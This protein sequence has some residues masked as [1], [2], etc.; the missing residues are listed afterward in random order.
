MKVLILSCSTG[1]GHNS[2]AKYIKQELEDNNISVDFYDF[3]DIVNEKAK[4]L[5]SK[6]YLMTLGNNGKLFKNIYKLGELYSKTKIKSPVYLVNK[7]YT[8]KLYDFIDKNKYDLI[9]T[10]HLFPALTLTAIN[11]N[12]NFTHI[13]FLFV[14]TDYEPCPFIEEAKPNYF[15]MQKGIE[16]KFYKKGIRKEKLLN[17]G[18]PIST[19]FIDNAKNIKK[20][21]NIL[22]E[23]VILIMLGSMGF[24]NINEI[25]NDLLKKDN[26]KIIIVCGSNENLF[27]SLNKIKNNKLIVLGFVNNINDLIYSSDIILSKPGGLSSTEIAVF[28]KPLIHIFP[29]PGIE[30]YNSE[31]FYNKKMS[32]KADKNEDIIKNINILLDN[33]NLQKDIINNQKKYINCYSGKDLIDFIKNNYKEK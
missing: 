1:G 27:N 21:F 26:I 6:M 18:I 16:N 11:K 15:I 14:A 7:L 29:I 19:K 23:K 31:F 24:G 9:I 2:C 28:R 32:L 17:F 22:N 3:F 12:E 5:S 33:E 20:D 8:T 25:I 4:D 13:N 30:T 10:T